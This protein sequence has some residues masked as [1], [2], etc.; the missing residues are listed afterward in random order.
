MQAHV[1]GRP[2]LGMQL[3]FCTRAAVMAH[4]MAAAGIDGPQDVLEGPYGYYALFEG[5]SDISATL[6]GL[7]AGRR[8]LEVS[9]KPFPAGRATHGVIDALLTLQGRHDFTTDEI[10][11]IRAEVPPLVHQLTGRPIVDDPAPNYARLCIPFVGATALL[12]G[13]VG[14]EDFAP[15]ALHEPS[16]HALARRIEV[17]INDVADPNALVPQT[18]GVR[19]IDGRSF[20]L[21]LDEVLGSPAKP[22]SR[23][24]HLA[25]FRRNWETAHST[26]AADRAEALIDAVD[27]LETLGDCTTLVDLMTI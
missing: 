16:T 22:L 20:E 4:D 5:D 13:G 23:E 18:V 14:I 2:L 15:D 25:K 9:H 26:A 1:E 24:A 17:V 7:A 11:T 27:T 19:L 21:T 8:I 3:G 6:A 10:D 12:R